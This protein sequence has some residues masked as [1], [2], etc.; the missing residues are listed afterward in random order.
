MKKLMVN[1][2]LVTLFLF[3][4]LPFRLF[5]QNFPPGSESMLNT[6]DCPPGSESWSSA[7]YTDNISYYGMSASTNYSYQNSGQ[8]TT[9]L[10]IDW[11]SLVISNAPTTKLSAW[12]KIIEQ[13]L[14]I[15]LVMTNCPQDD[16]AIWTVN[17]FYEK[18]CSTTTKFVYDLDVLTQV[19]CCSNPAIS[20]QIYEQYKDGVLHKLFNIYKDA[21]C[22]IKC[23]RRQYVCRMEKDP[24]YGTW[25]VTITQVN[26]FSETSCSGD[27]NNIDCVTGLPTPCI[28]GSC[29]D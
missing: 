18:K 4:L 11:S 20:Q 17:F 7:T 16:G 10:K 1:F 24:L 19:I 21:E 13:D 25:S 15:Y 9:N 14:V 28:D 23:C 3:I 26:T 8:N 5:S 6:V 22:G 12:K 2:T 29:S 27:S